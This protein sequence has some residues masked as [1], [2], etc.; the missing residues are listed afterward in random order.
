VSD[1]FVKLTYIIIF[2]KKTEITNKVKRLRYMENHNE[3][4]KLILGLSPNEKRYFKVSCS[5]NGDKEDFKYI[6]LFDILNKNIDITNE[7]LSKKLNVRQVSVYKK[8][9][10]NKIL[11]TLHTLEA[12]DPKIE[13][14]NL[15]SKTEILIKRGLTASARKT[16]EKAYKICLEYELLDLLIIVLTNKLVL[17]MAFIDSISDEVYTKITSLYQEYCYYI[18]L[19]NKVNKMAYHYRAMAIFKPKEF[20]IETFDLCQKD[21]DNHKYMKN[22]FAIQYILHYQNN[23][24]NNEDHDI[25]ERNY[26]Q[27]NITKIKKASRGHRK[28][29]C[30]KGDSNS[31]TLSGATT[32]K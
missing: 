23:Y 7:E 20:D 22:Y 13:V 1:I 8:N 18:N 31:H 14:L 3:L 28:A 10:F 29:S 12:Y 30:G 4:A 27:N 25:K 15:L 19:Q 17:A 32:S 9:L 16:L 6:K 5:I 21:V 24:N 2:M 11:D 26:M